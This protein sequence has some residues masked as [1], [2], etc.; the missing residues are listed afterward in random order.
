M[1]TFLFMR[2]VVLTLLLCLGVHS[3]AQLLD[4]IGLFLK[5]QPRVVVKLDLRGTFVSNR[6]ARMIGAKVGLEHAR[7]F[8]YGIGYS[9]LSSGLEREQVVSGQGL[10]TTRLRLGF[11][12]PYI[13]Y[14]FYQRGP[15]EI[16][17]PVQLGLGAGSVVFKGSD[18]RTRALDRSLVI[19]Y[20]P[21]MTVQYR[22]ARYF[23][24]G[25]GWGFRIAFHT[26]SSLGEQLTAPVYT[27]GL[28]V[29]LG[30]IWRDMGPQDE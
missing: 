4:S 2:A 23:A 17:I 26:R 14:A 6:S 9:F 19:L 25:G 27:F 12:T 10:V 7:R 29:F 8:Q 16:R 5:E 21:A 24:I 30:D 13:D 18:G 28:R 1:R 3:H 15:W 22:F 11:I 20:E